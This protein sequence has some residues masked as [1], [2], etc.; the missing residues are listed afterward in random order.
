MFKISRQSVDDIGIIVD[1]RVCLESDGRAARFVR[2]KCTKRRVYP[3][4]FLFWIESYF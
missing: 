1:W 4:L 3:N 2:I